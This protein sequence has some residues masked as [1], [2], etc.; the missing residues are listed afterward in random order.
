VKSVR[1]HRARMLLLQSDHNASMAAA[2]VG[3]E[4][5]SQFGREFKRLFGASPGE[6]AANL[7][8]RL[9]VSNEAATAVVPDRRERSDWR[10]A[11]RGL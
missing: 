3:Y 1:L 5:A 10:A 4:S 8:A 11:A 2:A 6:E 7:R 9:A